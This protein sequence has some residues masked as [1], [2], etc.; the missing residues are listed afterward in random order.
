MPTSNGTDAGTSLTIY[1][2]A[3]TGSGDAAC[4]N[5]PQWAGLLCRTYPAAAPS[6]GPTMPD[7]RITA[8]TIDAAPLTVSETSGTTVRTTTVTYA[9]R[10]PFLYQRR[11]GDGVDWKPGAACP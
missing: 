7:Q 9:Q 10:R 6:T 4:D 2:Q 1:Y 11:R 5:K 3:D 8:Y